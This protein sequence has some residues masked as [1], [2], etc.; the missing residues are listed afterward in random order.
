MMVQKVLEE[1]KAKKL[2][3]IKEIEKE[4]YELRHPEKPRMCRRCL[5]DSGCDES[6]VIL[7]SP[8]ECYG[9]EGRIDCEEE[10]LYGETNEVHAQIKLLDEL[11]E[12]CGGRRIR[13]R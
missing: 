12:M 8:E 5:A 6:Q 10:R 11:I 7:I 4:L 3:R 13:R 2:A 1:I 9:E